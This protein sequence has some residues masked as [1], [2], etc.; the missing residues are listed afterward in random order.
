[1]AVFAF[2]QPSDSGQANGFKWTVISSWAALG[3]ALYLIRNRPPSSALRAKQAS[4]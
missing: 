3:L 4:E 1:M 2:L